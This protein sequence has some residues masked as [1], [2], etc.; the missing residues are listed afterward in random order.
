MEV[1]LSNQ[2]ESPYVL[3]KP[4][5]LS[6][7]DTTHYKIWT[8]GTWGE[9]KKHY[10]DWKD[11]DVIGFDF[12]T[13]GLDTWRTDFK[14][15]GIGLAWKE[16]GQLQACYITFKGAIKPG[17]VCKGLMKLKSE[18]VAH[19]L[20]FDGSILAKYNKG[21][22][23]ENVLW[24]T[25]ALA[26]HLASEGWKGQ[27]WGLKNLM[28]DLLGWPHSNEHKL[29]SWLCVNEYV[30]AIRRNRDEKTYAMASDEKG[31]RWGIPDKSMMYMAPDN[32][33]AEYCI[34]DSI[35]TLL[36]YTDVMRPCINRFP[37]YEAYYRGP[38]WRMLR[39]L[40]HSSYV[41]IPI[42]KEKMSLLW[43]DLEQEIYSLEQEILEKIDYSGWNAIVI[44]EHKEKEPDRLKKDS[45][46]SKTWMNW[47]ERLR[48][49]QETNYFDIGSP[50]CLQWLFYEQMKL[51]VPFYTDDDK[52]NPSVD[53]QALSTLGPIGEMVRKYRE[54]CQLQNTFVTAYLEKHIDSGGQIHPGYNVPGTLTGR[55]SG[56]RPNIQQTTKD[57]RF[58][59][60]IRPLPGRAWVD[61]DLNSLENIIAA[62]ITEDKNMNILYKPGS[63][64]DAHLHTAAG[65]PG[66]LGAK[67][68]Q[69]YDP[70]NPTK[71]GVKLAEKHCYEERS[72][73]K[74]TN[75]AKIYGI[76]KKKYY[77]NLKLAGVDVDRS[78]SDKMHESYDSTYPG[79]GQYKAKLLREWHMRGGWIRNAMGRPCPVAKDRIK[80][81]FSQSVQSGGHDI[82]LYYAD[83]VE[84]T[85]N[86]ADIQDWRWLIPDWHDE[87]ILDVREEDAKRVAELIET[88]AYEKLNNILQGRIP[89]SGGS[90]IGKCL[91]PFKE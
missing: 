49:V 68:R 55:L 51:P 57:K 27:K 90:C 62:E 11:V 79:I 81:L 59:D 47:H 60:C 42:D 12:E 38:F 45:S 87:I 85:L 86:E 24:C 20:F 36:L 8:E 54:L 22:I 74:T 46:V 33:L 29:M 6:Y 67:V 28:T 37:E 58:L 65:F 88:V 13:T 72:Y 50:K 76:G 16:K 9:I 1:S 80:D 19:N 78:T 48:A 34:L 89:M 84:E 56:S 83:C 70:D 73:G 10:N 35:G 71:E 61:N 14:P 2:I 5:S 82:L 52:T 64:A 63:V 17:P 39:R 69:Y 25:K 30:T 91:S 3:L 40:I 26:K 21:V 15:V 18:L 77:D 75:Y 7:P 44:A 32:I 4:V 53:D 41:G 43:C 66:A 31:H 23:P